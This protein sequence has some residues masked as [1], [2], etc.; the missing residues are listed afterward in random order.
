MN[1]LRCWIIILSSFFSLFDGS[2]EE[3]VL[4][5]FCIV[6]TYEENMYCLESTTL[7]SN[8]KYIRNTEEDLN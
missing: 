2:V 4:N 1:C 7:R 6:L 8:F 5:N 3:L